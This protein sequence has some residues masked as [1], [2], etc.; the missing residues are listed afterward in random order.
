MPRDI[1]L[2]STAKARQPAVDAKVRQALD[3]ANEIAAAMSKSRTGT[4]G[5]YSKNRRPAI[6]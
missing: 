5:I 2:P 6:A 1:V 3:A 4:G